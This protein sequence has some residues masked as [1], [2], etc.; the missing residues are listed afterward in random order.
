MTAQPAQQMIFVNLPVT[1]LARAMA[2][3]EAIG[4]KRDERFCS[5]DNGCVTLS[6]TIVVMLLTHKQFAQFTPKRISDPHET[7]QVLLS[8]SQ[9]S[10]AAVDAIT[11]KAAAAGGRIDVGGTH[12]EGFMYGRDF[13]DP[14]GHG[15]GVVW[16]DMSVFE[17]AHAAKAV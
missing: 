4:A 15:W 16:M 8:L 7:A 6:D 11:Q 2:F 14:D 3:Y 12:D 17:T 9:P 13:E 10:R 1:D 5:P